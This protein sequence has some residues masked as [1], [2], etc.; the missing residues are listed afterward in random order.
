MFR[1]KGAM[2]YYRLWIYTC[3]AVLFVSVMVF[4]GTSLYVVTDNR[5]Q[6][7]SSVRLYQPS[8]LY[9]Y[10][11]L[12]M[13]SGVV[14]AIGCI[15]ALKLDER[16][17]KAYWLLL[18][19]L[20]VG[21]V[22]VGGY[23]MIRYD[24]L[25]STLGVD[26]LT[27]FNAE[28]T[29]PNSDFRSHFDELQRDSQCCG[30]LGPQDYNATWWQSRIY[31][32]LDK[33]DAEE[34]EFRKYEDILL[35]WACCIPNHEGLQMQPAL[36]NTI[37]GRL[38]A[39]SQDEE[40]EEEIL[41]VISS[42]QSTP[43]TVVPPRLHPYSPEIMIAEGPILEPFVWCR[44][45]SSFRAQW[46]H[47][48]GCHEPFKYWLDNSADA[49]FVIGFCVIGFLKFTFL[50]LL[51]FEIKEMIQKIKIIH[52]ENQQMNGDLGIMD[53]N[54]IP[55]SLEPT[56]L[57]D[58][59]CQ[60]S[61]A[62]TPR[63][64]SPDPGQSPIGHNVCFPNETPGQQLLNHLGGKDLDSSSCSALLASQ[65]S[66]PLHIPVNNHVGFIPAK[67]IVATPMPSLLKGSSNTSS[68]VI[69]NPI[70][71]LEEYHELTDVC[72]P[73]PSPN[74]ITVPIPGRGSAV[75]TAI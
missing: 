9:A 53:L 11:A 50:G 49:L 56:A 68:T 58:E 4:L 64:P 38:L 27:K 69:S 28:Y 48:R 55:S 2:R 54:D 23:W 71:T 74:F 15:G 21:D 60:G 1:I 72:Q 43:V 32:T 66:T 26:L 17:L 8:F 34:A 25:S 36:A 52:N 73:T 6:L 35:P 46:H 57:M 22:V 51:R 20:L 19:G 63:K 39:K 67:V 18:L 33:T 14:Q 61:L 31:A 24:R 7:I 70:Q 47:H 29:D 16:L 41:D 62:S 75:Q 5:R 44:Y 65:Q 45:S 12:F 37:R 40:D 42:T 3:N 13:Q 59:P 30:V 10:L